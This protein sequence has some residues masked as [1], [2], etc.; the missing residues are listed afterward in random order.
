MEN[1]CFWTSAVCLSLFQHPYISYIVS[2]RF[3][4][5]VPT[6]FG[7]STAPTSA[8]LI[9]SAY[10]EAV[11]LPSKIAN[12]RAI[13]QACPDLEMIAYSDGSS[14]RTVTLLQHAAD[15]VRLI[16]CTERAGKAV[17]IRRMIREARGEIVI[18]TDANVI[19]EPASIALL[20]HYFTDP[21]IGGVAGSLRY[22]NGNAGATARAGGLYWRLEEAIKQQESRVG[23]IMGAD[24]SI[25]A[26]RRTLYPMVPPDLL[27]DMTASL[28][29][30]LAGYR[31]THS[32]R[33]VAY[34]KNATS[35]G[36]E[37]RRKRRIACRAFHTHRYLWPRLSSTYGALEIYKYISHKLLR[38]LGL[39]PLVLGLALL[40]A[41]L[42]LAGQLPALK[43]LLG[44]LA[45]FMVAGSAGVPGFNTAYQILVAITATF[46]GVTD[47]LRGRTIPVWTPAASRN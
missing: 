35:A 18:F 19:L 40:S 12:L 29:V 28:S 25:F 44:G 10:N 37:F 3:M 38:W 17:G 24:G 47:A 34:E 6:A 45:L 8:T 39:V 21:G 9:F 22:L 46:L 30:T 27:D 33:V 42:T 26:M 20:L 16:V 2:L 41:G 14:D 11:A 7:T 13:Q 15:V 31:L 43:L 32:T 5:S 4:P 23:S 36:D 1:I